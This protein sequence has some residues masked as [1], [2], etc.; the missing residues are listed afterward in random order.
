MEKKWVHLLGWS[1]A[2]ICLTAPALA[3]EEA[4]ITCHRTISAGL[5]ADWESSKHSK[6]DVTCSVCHGEAH[7]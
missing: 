2:I 5:V 3:A 7:Q 4:C 1:I 6:E